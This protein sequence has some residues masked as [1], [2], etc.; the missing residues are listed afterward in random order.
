MTCEA[1]PFSCSEEAEKGMNF[2]C[3]PAPYDIIEIKKNTDKNWACHEHPKEDVP[4]AGWAAYAK[5]H[6]LDYKTGGL[7]GLSIW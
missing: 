7:V 6:G 2:G 5:E 1:C 4:C 3:L